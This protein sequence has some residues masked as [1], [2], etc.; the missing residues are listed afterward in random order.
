[1][2]SR[3]DQLV[4]VATLGAFVVVAG[5]LGLVS[6]YLGAVTQATSGVQRTASLPDWD[7]R[8]SPQQADG[9][10][11]M[12]YLVLVTDESGA[13]A[14]AYLAQLS[15]PRNALQ[16]IGLAAN[17]LVADAQGRD[18]TLASQFTLGGAQAV[19]AI[20]SQLRVRIDHL[21]LVDLDG[22]TGIVDVIGGVTVHNRMEMA[23]E[24]WHFNAG[25]LRLNGAEALI[26]LSSPNQ[27]MARLERTE[28]VFVEIV[29]GLVGG[30]ALANP[31][32]VEAIGEVLHSCVVV[33]AAL[34]AGEIR[35]MAL[36]MHL[37]GDSIQAIPLPLAG[38]SDLDGERVVV[39]D[40]DRLK[41]LSD[42]LQNDQ[43]AAWAAVQPQPWGHLQELPPR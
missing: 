35:R 14:S 32:K 42:A 13:L 23:A 36:D 34:T 33:D 17:L 16:L 38:A 39:A 29:R 10:R 3:S 12:R 43:V 1:M 2:R 7:G 15:G 24:G 6:I 18:A 21:V 30:D 19:R 4:A 41:T 37:T 11:P 25:E 5:V 31:T 27:T 40:P 28:A 9:T 26:Y 20:E 22:F 8:P